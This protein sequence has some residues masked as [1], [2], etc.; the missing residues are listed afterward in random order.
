MLFLHGRHETCY[1]G[2]ESAADWPCPAGFKPLPSYR[3]YLETQRLLASQGYDTVSISANGI[4]GQDWMLGDGGAEARSQLVRHHLALWQPWSRSD[5]RSRGGSGRGQGGSARRP[6]AGSCWSGTHAGGEGVN[7]AALDSTTGAGRARGPSRASS[8]S[9]RPRSGRTR[10]PASPSWSSCPTA[11]ATSPTCRVRPTSTRPATP[12]RTRC[13]AAPSSSSAPTTTSSTPSG[14][15]ASPWPRPSTTGATTPTGSAATVPGRRGS[16]PAAQRQVGTTYVA[17]AAA[18]FV[19]G[20]TGPL[21]LLDGTKARA[22]SAGSARVLTHALGGQ[23][24]GVPRADEHHGAHHSG[25]VAARTCKTAEANDVDLEC[26][27]D[28]EFGSTPHF[29]PLYSLPGEPSRRAI[30]VSWTKASGAARVDLATARSLVGARSLDA[31]R[32]RPQSVRRRRR[33][34]SGLTDAAGHRLTLAD[35]SVTGLPADR[36]AFSGKTWAQEV[37]L[38]LT[39]GA[40]KASALDLAT[41]TRVEVLP[42][43][44][45]GQLFVLDAW[46]RQPGLSTAAPLRLSRID[47]GRGD[48]R[49]GRDAA[50]R[51]GCR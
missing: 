42:R 2:D 49:G 15:R 4:N 14:P 38:P 17:A 11:T 45:T 37:R 29:L 13:C 5:D 47:V 9:V 50:H 40:V 36:Q 34:A 16:T 8:T 22:A 48:G 33:S 43:S 31:A 30:D 28:A 25:A 32:R 12:A 35:V 41:I 39:A 7:R 21:P 23:T 24:D 18:V 1:L 27:P 3:G 20:D 46:G 44:A 51:R 26:I 10:R 19:A 6:R